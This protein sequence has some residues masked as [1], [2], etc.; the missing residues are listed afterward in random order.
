MTDSSTS[1]LRCKRATTLT[2][3]SLI[4]VHHKSMAAVPGLPLAPLPPNTSQTISS[5][6]TINCLPPS[7]RR[8]DEER[9]GTWWRAAVVSFEGYDERA[10][11][12]VRLRF[13]CCRNVEIFLVGTEQSASRCL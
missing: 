3:P 2:L 9:L 1:H 7:V 11:L 10:S 5:H 4:F 13:P 12:T 8:G 6:V